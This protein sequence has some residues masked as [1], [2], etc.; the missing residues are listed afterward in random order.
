[1]SNLTIILTPLFLLFHMVVSAQNEEFM[2]EEI[3]DHDLPV[4]GVAFSP[5]GKFLAT[6]SEDVT[7]KIWNLQDFSELMTLEGHFQEINDVVFSMDGN[8]LI[9]AGD[10][11]I[12]IWDVGTWTEE[13]IFIGHHTYVWSVNADPTLSFLASGSF[14]KQP[15][16]WNV[17]TGESI[18]L[19]GH[20]KSVLATAISPDGKYLASGSL[21]ENIMLWDAKTHQLIKIFEGHSDNIYEITFTPGGKHFVSVSRDKTVRLWSI[22]QGGII[23][24]YPGHRAGVMTV[25]VSNDGNFMLTGSFDGEIKLWELATATELYTFTHHKEAVTGVRFSPDFDKFASSSMDETAIVWNL[26]KKIFI[27]YHYE[28]QFLNELEKNELFAPRQKDESRSDYNLREEK[29]AAFKKELYNNYFQKYLKKLEQKK[30]SL[31]R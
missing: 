12:R 16:I 15:R 19:E 3:K 31:I 21:D 8:K 20:D 25:D 18:S 28:E 7:T 4:L 26:D 24:T 9:T 10:R 1:M 5:D 14:D 23:K 13:K 22:E 6:C 30:A 17:N 2:L 27:D 11:S 29:A